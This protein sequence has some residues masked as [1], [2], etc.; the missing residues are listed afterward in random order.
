[1]N[2]DLLKFYECVIDIAKY[3]NDEADYNYSMCYKYMLDNYPNCEE[4]LD[5]FA[6]LAASLYE[7]SDGPAGQAIAEEMNEIEKT[8][9]SNRVP[10]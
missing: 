7:N 1:M 3:G 2:K 6:E 8:L 9:D 10:F 5:R 4:L